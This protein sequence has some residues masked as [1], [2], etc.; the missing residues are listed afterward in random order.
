MKEHLWLE[1]VIVYDQKGCCTHTDLLWYLPTVS[2]QVVLTHTLVSAWLVVIP[3][4]HGTCIS[5]SCIAY[6]E[7]KSFFVLVLTHIWLKFGLKVTSQYWGVTERRAVR[8]KTVRIALSNCGGDW[9]PFACKAG[10]LCHWV[11]LGLKEFLAI[12]S[13]MKS[14]TLW[15]SHL[16]SLSLCFREYGYR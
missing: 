14:E 5:F 1:D 6:W 4:G 11:I 7:S 8:L 13:I 10:I 2:H 16:K 3:L 15:Y 9:Q 12:W